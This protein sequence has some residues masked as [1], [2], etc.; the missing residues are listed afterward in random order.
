[1]GDHS[2]DSENDDGFEEVNP[3]PLNHTYQNVDL[4]LENRGRISESGGFDLDGI[5]RFSLV[6]S[7]DRVDQFSLVP[8]E[9]M[10][11]PPDQVSQL[12][13]AVRAAL[14]TQSTSSATKLL[15]A[16]P[17]FRREECEDVQEF[18][19]NYKRAACLNG[20]KDSNLA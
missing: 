10:N 7:E 20:W 1:M 14:N 4:N 18:V 16:F 19:N 3:N 15:V 5:D 12:C 2:S 17:V 8:S 9:E 11:D 6:P 13:D